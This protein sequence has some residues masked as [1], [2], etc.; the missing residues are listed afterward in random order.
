[1]TELNEAA[2]TAAAASVANDDMFVRMA[3]ALAVGLII[4]VRRGWHTRNAESGARRLAFA[5]S[6]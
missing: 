2:E 3:L 4:G 5:P 6:P 1:M